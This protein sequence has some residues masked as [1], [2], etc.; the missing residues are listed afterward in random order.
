MTSLPRVMVSR[1]AIAGMTCGGMK[2]TRVPAAG[3][4]V[5]TMG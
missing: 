5:P 3:F 1:W 2:T 4:G